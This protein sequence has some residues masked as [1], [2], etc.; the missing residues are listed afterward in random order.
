MISP[1]LQGRLSVFSACLPGWE[2]QRVIDSASHL[3][4]TRVEWASGPGHAIGQP[5]QGSQVQELC[6]RAGVEVVGISVQDPEVTLAAPARAKEHVGLAVTLGAPHM[7][8][9]AP[10]YQGGSLRTEQERA[11]S[12]LDELVEVASPAGVAV[13]VETSPGTLAPGPEL[14][15]AL[16]EHQPPKFAGVLYDPGNMAIEGHLAPGVAVARL[17]EHLRHVHVKNI[18]WTRSEGSWRWRHATLAEGMLD[19]RS[20]VRALA[21]AQY[22]GMFSIDHL[23]GEVTDAKLESETALLSTLVANGFGP[24]GVRTAGPHAEGGPRSTVNA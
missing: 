5:A 3:G 7:R 12:G 2:A 21:A 14:A 16:V 9:L 1:A 22:R 19:W 8:L 6:L 13:L 10:A 23:G 20:I 17:G 18:A 24:D 15:A 4:F 11:R